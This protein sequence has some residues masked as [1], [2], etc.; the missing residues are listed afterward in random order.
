MKRILQLMSVFIFLQL[1]IPSA[2]SAK[3]YNC[4]D[5]TKQDIAQSIPLEDACADHMTKAATTTTAPKAKGV[6][7]PDKELFGFPVW[8]KY[9]AQQIETD[10]ETNAQSCHVAFQNIW[11]VWLIVAAV[12]E[13]MLR[14]A[15]IAAIIFVLVGGVTYIRSQGEPETTK[16]A[17]KTI[18]NALIGLVI[19]IA[20]TAM[21]AY[22]A[23]K[24]KG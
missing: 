6:C 15:M 21:V 1:M 24:F 19:S 9:L 11:D 3:I 5:G 17:L 18:I 20:A 2:V 14:L 13:M 23:G 22:V 8:Y 7:E 4:P 10:P 12:V 16:K